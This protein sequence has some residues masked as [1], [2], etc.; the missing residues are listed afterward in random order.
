VTAT[1][2][3]PVALQHFE[4]VQ[5]PVPAEVFGTESFEVSGLRLSGGPVR[6]VLTTDPGSVATRGYVFAVRHHS[7]AN[8]VASSMYKGAP[9]I[10]QFC[11]GR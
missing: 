1:D 3:D 2:S 7:V 10:G 8:P 5:E 4:L 6:D 9:G 11:D